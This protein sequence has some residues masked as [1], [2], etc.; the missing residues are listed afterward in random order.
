M[1]APDGE[2]GAALFA[3]ELGWK[4]YALVQ[5]L[6]FLDHREQIRGLRRTLGVRA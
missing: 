3:A 1:G 6:H 5:R 4:E 2:G